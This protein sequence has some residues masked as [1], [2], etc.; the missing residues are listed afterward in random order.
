M[1]LSCRS[2]G[3]VV[4]ILATGSCRRGESGCLSGADDETRHNPQEGGR[5]S[6]AILIPFEPR[7]VALWARAKLS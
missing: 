2:V 7:S 5:R 6:D 4:L 3:R 1:A